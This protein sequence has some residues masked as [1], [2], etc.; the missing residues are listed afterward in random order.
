MKPTIREA[1]SDDAELLVRVVDMASEGLIPAM[2]SELAPEGLDGSAVGMAQVTAEDGDFSYRNGYVLEMDGAT[3]GG[4]IGYPLPATPEP[5]G[6]EV[7]DV[8]VAIEELANLTPGYWYINFMAVVP[9]SRGQ[10]LGSALLDKAESAAQNS[11]CPGISLIVAANNKV[12]MRAY[13]RGGFKEKARRPFDLTDFGAEATEAI[14]M[15]K[16]LS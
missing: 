8:F 14:L 6:A 15:V 11:G 13:S 9:E 12:A 3:L 4:L 7:P 2:W 1:S 16:E 5:A 10:G